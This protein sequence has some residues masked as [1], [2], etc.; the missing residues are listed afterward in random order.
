VKEQTGEIDAAGLKLGIVV[1]RFN[2][3][4]T[5][6][7]L[8]GALDTILRTGGGEEDIAVVRVPGSFE[9]PIAAKTLAQTG[10]YDAIICLGCLI[11]GETP[12]FEYLAAAVTSGIS[13]ISIQTGI[14]IAYGV[15]TTDT[16]EQA[17]N[18]AGIKSG[19]KGSEAAAAGIEMA[20]LIR[21]VESD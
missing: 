8:E 10:K 7:L 2:S 16:V 13:Q 4:I 17:L 11:R 21:G 3:V 14:P 5:D 12:H 19:N 6:K 15:L 9:I 20:N 18:R 1:S